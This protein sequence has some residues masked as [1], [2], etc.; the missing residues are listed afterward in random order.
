MKVEIKIISANSASIP[1]CN[2][3]AD[4]DIT[5][6]PIASVTEGEVVQVC[7]LLS[8]SSCQGTDSE[9]NL[10][11]LS[12]ITSGT[13]CKFEGCLYKIVVLNVIYLQL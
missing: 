12:T 5:L 11:A 7:V 6:L 13:A 4:G 1:V 2:I 3:S 8:C 9:F 10:Q